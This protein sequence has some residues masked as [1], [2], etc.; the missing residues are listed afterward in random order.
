MSDRVFTCGCCGA[1]S[2]PENRIPFACEWQCM[3]CIGKVADPSTWLR[4]RAQAILDALPA[5]MD[6]VEKHTGK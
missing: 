2:T 4:Q 3:A 1:V 6:V 5:A